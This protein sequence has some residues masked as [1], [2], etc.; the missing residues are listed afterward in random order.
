MADIEQMIVIVLTSTTNSQH[1]ISPVYS[2]HST[3]AVSNKE[4]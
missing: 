3:Q 4:G 1:S 2:L